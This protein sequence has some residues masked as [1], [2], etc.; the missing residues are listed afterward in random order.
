MW[1]GCLQKLYRALRLDEFKKF[2]IKGNVMDM[3]VGVVIGAAFGK[4]TTS[5]VNDVIMGP[6]GFLTGKGSLKGRYVTLDGRAYDSLEMARRE[7]APVI[8]Y[9]DFL[10]N[11]IDFVL[12][13][14]VL[15][16]VV[17]QLN[18]LKAQSPGPPPAPQTKECPECLSKIPL[19]ARR[20][21]QCAQPVS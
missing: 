14:F 19:Q 4:I 6:L 12:M 17:K 1:K 3:A 20:C 13:A 21:A 2:A 11:L 16:L 5:L 18:K 7:Q 9:G 8:V 15:F 10:Q